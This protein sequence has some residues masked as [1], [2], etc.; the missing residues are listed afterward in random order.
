MSKTIQF[1]TL[2]LIVQLL[3]LATVLFTKNQSTETEGGLLLEFA[4]ESVDSLIIG[5][6]TGELEIKK[7]GDGWYLP[8]YGELAVKSEKVT[9]I[10]DELA[11]LH[12][13]WPVATTEDAAKR[14]EVSKENAQKSLQLKSGDEIVGKLYLG[15]SPGFRKVHARVSEDDNVYAVEFSQYRVSTKGEDWFDKNFLAYKKPVSSLKVGDTQFSKTDAGWNVS[16]LAAEKTD[17]AEVEGWVKNIADLQVN[18]LITGNDKDKLLVLDPNLEIQV[19][20][21]GEVVAYRLWKKGENYYIKRADNQQLFEIMPHQAKKYFELD[22]SN[23]AIDTGEAGEN[24][25][26]DGTAQ[27]QSSI[28][29]SLTAGP[30]AGTAE[31]SSN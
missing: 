1:L 25:S 4:V 17:A 9:E 24:E 7:Q 11:K 6:G 8:G 30:L 15:T 5:D 21:E 2:A 29:D 26:A 13:S 31:T 27:S 10:L 3:I 18:K 28:S 12:T 20:G 16:G 22:V 14:F 19:Q 23:F